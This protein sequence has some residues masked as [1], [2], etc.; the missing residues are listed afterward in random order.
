MRIIIAA[1][2]IGLLALAGASPA[3]A[4]SKNDKAMS[5]GS[6]TTDDPAAERNNFTN[7]AK[8]EMKIWE[9]KLHDYNAKRTTNATEVQAGASR[10]LNGA[11]RETQTAWT[12]LVKVDLNVGTAGA[13]AWASAQADFQTASQKLASTWQKAN[14]EA[15]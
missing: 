9:G 5:V 4:Q 10:N 2:V 3:A 7:G 14:P 11:W 12:Q 15:K 1:T 13:N 8:D 6:S